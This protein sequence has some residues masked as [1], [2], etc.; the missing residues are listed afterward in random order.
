MNLGSLGFVGQACACPLDL[1]GPL[2][3]TALQF[4]FNG[5]CNPPA[6]STAIGT[7]PPMPWIA[8]IAVG[9]GTWTGTGAGTP[10]PGPEIV[11]ANESFQFYSGNCSPPPSID[12]D[13][14]VMTEGGFSVL[15]NIDRPGLTDR[16]L[17]IASNYSAT[18]GISP[19]FVGTAE[20]T[21]HIIQM[22]F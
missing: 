5:T 13:Y 7:P 21:Q 2:Q 15:P 20:R 12:V 16:M 3:Y 4:G 14:G 10:F 18:S 11:W 6:S 17:D 9:L 1:S 19:P 8:M 22:S